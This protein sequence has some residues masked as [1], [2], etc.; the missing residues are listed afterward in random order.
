MLSIYK[1]K[2]TCKIYGGFCYIFGSLQ[3]FSE[4]DLVK[5]STCN[6][7]EYN[8][9]FII[10]NIPM[11]IKKIAFYSNFNIDIQP[12]LHE[13]I[14]WIQFGSK[15]N[16]MVDNL[17]TQLLNLSFGKSFNQMVNN[18]PLGLKIITFGENFNQNIDMLPEFVEIIVLCGN[19][20][21][22]ICNLPCGLRCLRLQGKKFSQSINSLPDSIQIL[23]LHSLYNFDLINKLPIKLQVVKFIYGVQL[24]NINKL[25]LLTGAEIQMIYI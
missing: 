19:F 11:N 8:L 3:T 17:P 13:E 21:L 22:P 24:P 12:Y 10:K 2:K 4:N 20:N 6:Y 16:Q 7:M 15:F 5:I 9:Y 1:K 14:T 18:L 25:K 23:Q